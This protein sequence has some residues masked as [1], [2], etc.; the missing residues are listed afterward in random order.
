MQFECVFLPHRVHLTSTHMMNDPK[1]SFFDFGCLLVH[2]SLERKEKPS[3]YY[4]IHS[5][6]DVME[7]VLTV[8]SVLGLYRP[9]WLG[10]VILGPFLYQ[11]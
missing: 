9:V 10:V 2:C 3:C 1:P 6:T 8:L 7:L 11:H 5:I 4:V